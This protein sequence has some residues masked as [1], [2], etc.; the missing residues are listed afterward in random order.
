MTTKELKLAAKNVNGVLGEG[1]I[2]WIGNFNMETKKQQFNVFFAKEK[3]AKKAL[4][5]LS[6]YGKTRILKTPSF[7]NSYFKFAVSVSI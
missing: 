2:N 3:E 6:Q 7:I 4:L 5:S 1:R